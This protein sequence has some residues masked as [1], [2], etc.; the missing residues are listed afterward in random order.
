VYKVGKGKGVPVHEGILERETKV[1]CPSRWQTCNTD[2]IW[3]NPSEAHLVVNSEIPF[4]KSEVFSSH[5]KK[6]ATW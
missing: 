1:H 6:L 3:Q 2:P 4:Q 5:S